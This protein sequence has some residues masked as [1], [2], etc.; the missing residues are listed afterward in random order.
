MSFEFLAP[1][2][3]LVAAHTK[4]LSDQTLGKQ[5]KIHTTSDGVPDLDK[6]DIAI[7]GVQENRNDINFLGEQLNFDAIRKSLYEL[8]PGNWNTSMVD[9]GDVISGNQVSDTYYLVQDVLSTLLQK[10]IIPIIIGGSQDLVYAQYRSFDILERMVNL[11]NVDSR[12]DLGNSAEDITNTSFVGKIIVEQPYNLFNYSNIGYQT[13]FNAQEE[14]DL[15]EKLYFDSYRLG[16]VIADVTVV[17][18]I[19]RDADIVSIDLG[20]MNANSLNGITTSPNGFDGREICAISRYAGISDKVKSFGIYEFKN[21]KNEETAAVL[22]S[23]II[24]YF[25]EGVNYRSN[26]L[27]IKNLKNTL[28]YNVPI[29][30]EI[31]SFYKSP[32][33]GRWWIEI[34]FISSGNN[35]LKRHTLLP[36]TYNDYERACNQEIPE[37]WYKAKRKNEV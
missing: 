24:W 31:L 14:I 9:L 37:R 13:Y 19:M 7:L 4:L 1:V 22:I 17:E 6:V 15:I 27:D 8:F 32:K 20:V 35:K 3:D 23:Q 21:F 12:F 29:D 26:E 16:E 34:P 5:I 28:H 30:D 33:T 25:I 10:N 2:S 18:P 36:C 11:A